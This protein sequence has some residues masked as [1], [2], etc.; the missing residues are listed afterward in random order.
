MAATGTAYVTVDG[1]GTLENFA[2]TI[3][4]RQKYLKETASA[5]VTAMA[6]DTLRSLRS[7]TRVVKKSSIKVEVKPR[8][9]LRFS[10]TSTGK[11]ADVKRK[12]KK[13]K[14]GEK[15]PGANAGNCRMCIRTAGGQRVDVALVRFAE[16]CRG[17]KLS[18]IKCFEFVDDFTTRKT[19]NNTNRL[20]VIAAPSKAAAVKAA[21]KIVM[22]RII[23]Y[24]GLARRAMS[25][26]MFKANNVAP[27]DNVTTI[28]SR[29]AKQNTRITRRDKTIFGNSGDYSIL[30]EDALDYAKNALK[31][32]DAAIRTSLMK[33]AN[34]SAGLISQRA[35]K[36]LDNKP[37]PT[38][39]PEI[40][41][42]HKKA[43]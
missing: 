2:R 27:A 35:K 25:A 31:G 18:A 40:V 8:N 29:V 16:G 9:D 19:G 3:Q 17:A 43:S 37:L 15:Q 14:K 41:V 6:M 26:L 36:L 11:R 42:Q 20:Y 22:N 33:A 28:A 10:Y 34:K 12:K 24:A 32:G 23:L 13:A 1:H 38:P 7:A 5:A 30:I 21:R 4:A 39:F